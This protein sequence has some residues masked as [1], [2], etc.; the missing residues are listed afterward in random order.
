M[1]FN[2]K[3][4]SNASATGNSANIFTYGNVVDGVAADNT[5]A[6]TVDGFFNDAS[7][8]LD[9]GNIIL[10]SDGATPNVLTVTSLKGVTPVTTVALPIV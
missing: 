7:D 6:I 10:V 4:L 9:M 8:V 5:A 2:R 1:A 3:H